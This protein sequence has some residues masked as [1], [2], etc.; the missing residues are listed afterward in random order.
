MISLDDYGNGNGGSVNLGPIYNSLSIIQSQ[1]ID[2]STQL[3]GSPYYRDASYLLSNTYQNGY[4]ITGT[5]SSTT[6]YGSVFNN[7]TVKSLDILQ[8]ARFDN[9]KNSNTSEFRTVDIAAGKLWNMVFH[10]IDCLKLKDNQISRNSF[11]SIVE[12]EL[13]VDI[14]NKSS[15][16]RLNTFRSIS[17]LRIKGDCRNIVYTNA[18]TFQN[19]SSLHIQSISSAM[20]NVLTNLPYL[21][22]SGEIFVD[23]VRLSDMRS[24]YLKPFE[25][26]QIQLLVDESHTS[27]FIPYE[28]RN[29][30]F[31]CCN[32]YYNSDFEYPDT[33]SINGSSTLTFSNLRIYDTHTNYLYDWHVSAPD[34]NGIPIFMNCGILNYME[35]N[36][37]TNP[38]LKARA[39][40]CTINMAT[41]SYEIIPTYSGLFPDNCFNLIKCDINHL[42]YFNSFYDKVNSYPSNYSDAGHSHASICVSCSLDYC[43]MRGCILFEGFCKNRIKNAILNAHYIQADGI[44]GNTFS[45]LY[46]SRLVSLNTLLPIASNSIKIL[47]L[48]GAST[49][50][51]NTS[52][53]SYL[54]L[55]SLYNT[56]NSVSYS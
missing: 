13:D 36:Y 49:L 47:R 18:N 9:F 35:Y 48:S 42:Y 46:I 20:V 43:Y 12:L 30:V 41:I 25:Y 38:F 55:T 7:F 17:H 50:P 51:S 1:I 27:E 5:L 32:L 54:N 34:D 11:A 22:D 6:L 24:D 39:S 40:N 16:Y 33:Q 37:R 52:L 2:I 10:T 19:I 3:G 28:T 44:E 4:N 31:H 23:E 29:F 21:I 8:N 15:D 45:T 56:I 14:R 53:V 26:N